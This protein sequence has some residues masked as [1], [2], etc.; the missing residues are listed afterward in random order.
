MQTIPET[1]MSGTASSTPSSEAFPVIPTT[2]RN[3]T[4]RKQAG[5]KP[6]RSSPLVNKPTGVVVDSEVRVEDATSPPLSRANQQQE[7]RG[8]QDDASRLRVTPS[9]SPADD[10]PRRSDREVESPTVSKPGEDE[11]RSRSES[12][13]SHHR[14]QHHHHH[15]HHHQH[16]HRHRRPSEVESEP[17]PVEAASFPDDE[18]GQLERRVHEQTRL[19]EALARSVEESKSQVDQTFKD[20]YK[21]FGENIKGKN[22]E[23]MAQVEKV[24]AELADVT[25][26]EGRLHVVVDKRVDLRTAGAKQPWDQRVQRINTKSAEA[27]ALWEQK[28]HRLDTWS[29]FTTA[30]S[31]AAAKATKDAGGEKA[32]DDAGNDDEV[33]EGAFEGEQEQQSFSSSWTSRFVRGLAL[34]GLVAGAYHLFS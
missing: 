16:S 24:L 8:E 11:P 5:F 2:G 12:A 7:G 21:R 19:V 29:R 20:V 27:I 4:A 25:E 10:E 14:H 23:F 9:S 33:V 34:A 17:S 6:I 13:S 30:V 31:Q 28:Q 22:I 26:M 32:D 18:I 1:A 3:P 15:H